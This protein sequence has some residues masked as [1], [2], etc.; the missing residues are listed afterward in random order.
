MQSSRAGGRRQT[1]AGSFT[2]ALVRVNCTPP[3]EGL[4]SRRQEA[5]YTLFPHERGAAKGKAR[6]RL[7]LLTN[8][9]KWSSP[10]RLP[11]APGVPL[12][13]CVRA[14][15]QKPYPPLIYQ[16]SAS[17]R[18]ATGPWQIT[19]EAE[20]LLSCCPLGVTALGAP[21]ASC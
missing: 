9:W 20:S 2:E 11:W 8:P 3:A 7:C 21:K 16:M 10:W 17:S 1:V 13:H 6:C 19:L 5:N 12:E 14:L 15:K 4:P 18:A